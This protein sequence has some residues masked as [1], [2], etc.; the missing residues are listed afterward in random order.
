MNLLL[1]NIGDISRNPSALNTCIINSEM[2]KVCPLLAHYSYEIP[3][4]CP[5][6]CHRAAAYLPGAVAGAFLQAEYSA[7]LPLP[8]LSLFCHCQSNI[9]R[10]FFCHFLCFGQHIR[11]AD[12]RLWEHLC[13]ELDLLVRQRRVVSLAF[14][15]PAVTGYEAGA[16]DNG[17]TYLPVGSRTVQQ[18]GAS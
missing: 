14:F 1:H 13:I 2:S 16:V 5:S 9:F 11:K 17:R 3:S 12:H 6:T 7:C 10:L 15:R 18:E 4:H 8:F